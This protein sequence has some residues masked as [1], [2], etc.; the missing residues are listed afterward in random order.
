MNRD[1]RHGLSRPTRKRRDPPRRVRSRL[2]RL[3]VNALAAGVLGFGGVV[4]ALS[5]DADQPINIR[6]RTV[7]ANEKTG[8]SVY[9]GKVVLT[10]GSLRLEADR[11][12][13]RLANGAIDTVRAWGKPVRM[14]T[15]TDRGE[16]IRASAQRA[17]YRAR[18]RKV[19]LYGDVEM[20][21]DADVFSGAVV[22]YAMD[23][24]TF[25]AEGGDGGQV[26]AVIQPAKREA[27][28]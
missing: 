5:T 20:H 28:R 15:R 9:Q 23:E 27:E 17:E 11:M 8:V 22:H 19:D 10:Q 16:E 4:F 24:Q 26:T 3:A 1:S 14:R 18:Q 21:R 12:E 25:V 2:A 6:A 13:V 7:E